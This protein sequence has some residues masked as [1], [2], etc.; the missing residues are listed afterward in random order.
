MTQPL[1]HSPGT[2][3]SP[4]VPPTSPVRQA[5]AE[6][7]MPLTNADTLE[8]VGV[9]EGELH[10]LCGACTAFIRHVLD[11]VEDRPQL[12]GLPTAC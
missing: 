9:E 3:L 7:M 12:L 5:G 4:P 1:T 11:T 8:L 10:E 6:F 2:P